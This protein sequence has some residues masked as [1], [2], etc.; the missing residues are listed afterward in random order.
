ML[1][2]ATVSRFDLCCREIKIELAV[3]R[4]EVAAGLDLGELLGQVAETA[5]FFGGGHN[6]RRLPSE[7][8]HILSRSAAASSRVSGLPNPSLGLSRHCGQK[9]RV[10][11]YPP[12]NP[13]IDEDTAYVGRAPLAH[14][15]VA[16]EHLAF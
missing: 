8:F 7:R 12:R 3:V 1:R 11:E 16:G 13:V 9:P 15:P 5:A 14:R 4:L 10:S 2:G 6:G